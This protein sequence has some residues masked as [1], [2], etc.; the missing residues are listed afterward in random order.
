[1]EISDDRER[2]VKC[3]GIVR[4][5]ATHSQ[6]FHLEQS[7]SQNKLLILLLVKQWWW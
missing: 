3:F 1:V 7:L 2:R 5:C 6:N 4:C